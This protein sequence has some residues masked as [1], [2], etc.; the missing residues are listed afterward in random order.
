MKQH[1]TLEGATKNTIAQR[2]RQYPFDHKKKIV[3]IAK[4][5]KINLRVAY[6]DRS[7]NAWIETANKH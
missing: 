1:R 2:S 4:D 6:S 3:K 7:E 5:Q